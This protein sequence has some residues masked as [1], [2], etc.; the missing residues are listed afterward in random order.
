MSN[1]ETD[2]EQDEFLESP[3]LTD[4]YCTN[5]RRDVEGDVVYDSSD[6]ET[7]EKLLQ[8]PTH[9]EFYQYIERREKGEAKYKNWIRKISENPNLAEEVEHQCG[10]NVYLAKNRVRYSY[11]PD[12]TV[13]HIPGIRYKVTIVYDKFSRKWYI[14]LG[15]SR[16]PENVTFSK[17]RIEKGTY[18]PI[19][20]STLRMIQ[21]LKGAL[22]FRAQKIGYV[23]SLID[24]AKEV[25]K[26][27]E[28]DVSLCL[29]KIQITLKEKAWPKDMEKIHSTDIIHLAIEVNDNF[30]VTNLSYE[31]A[32]RKGVGLEKR[33]MCLSKLEQ[34]LNIF[35]DLPFKEAFYMFMNSDAFSSETMPSSDDI[36]N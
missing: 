12:S 8:S 25:Y 7:R 26:D 36:F 17:K 14:S 2:N 27:I 11:K 20:P 33:K 4:I 18:D 34:K 9:K 19:G 16:L 35:S 29:S 24:N 1:Q 3:R 28:F 23:Y 10:M 32:N 30:H 21:N 6:P 31:Y 13:T 5:S 22:H 15:H